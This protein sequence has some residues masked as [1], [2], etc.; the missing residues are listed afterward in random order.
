MENIIG[1]RFAKTGKL[2]YMNPQNFQVKVGD[3]IVAMSERGQE[4]GRVVSIKTVDEFKKLD[5]KEEIIKIDRIATKQDMEKQKELD[6]EAKKAL[7]V[8]KKLAKKYIR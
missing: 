2:Y 3:K 4:I 5:Y 1:V 7:E 6:N 8:C